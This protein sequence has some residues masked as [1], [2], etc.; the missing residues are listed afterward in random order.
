M[1]HYQ[2]EE[3]QGVSF[4]LPSAAFLLTLLSFTSIKPASVFFLYVATVSKN[5]FPGLQDRDICPHQMCER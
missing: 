1:K 3:D 4:C 5:P 2:R